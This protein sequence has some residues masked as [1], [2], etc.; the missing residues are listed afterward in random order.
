MAAQAAQAHTPAFPVEHARLVRD[1]SYQFDFV[2]LAPPRPPAWLDWLA[3]VF[4][5]LSPVAPYLFWGG[6]AVGVG[7]LLVVIGREVL[8]ERGRSR[9]PAKVLTGAELAPS[10][11]RVRALLAEAD[12]LAAAGRFGEAVRVLLHRTLEDLGE[13]RPGLIA[14]SQTSREIAALPV[15]PPAVREPLAGIAA[16][17]ERFVFAGRALDDGAFRSCRAQYDRFLAAAS[18]RA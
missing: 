3:P 6:L 1:P 16:E 12:R 8:R 2:S 14:P 9:A 17:A 11:G 15:L 5:A 18:G 7:L 10:P 13:R 4:R